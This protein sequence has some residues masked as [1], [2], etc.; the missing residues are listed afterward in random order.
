VCLTSA[1]LYS[2]TNIHTYIHTRIHNQVN[3]VPHTYIYTY[4]HTQVNAV[5]EDDPVF[6]MLYK[7]L[8]Y[9]HIYLKV[10]DSLSL[11]QRM[12]SFYNYCNLFDT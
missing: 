4:I 6:L 11:E 2:Y 5:L 1:E 12:E 3:T 9:R 7:E 8:Y 10:A